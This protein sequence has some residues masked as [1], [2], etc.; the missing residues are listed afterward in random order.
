MAVRSTSGERAV[1]LI[2]LRLSRVPGTAHE[3]VYNGPLSIASIAAGP[4][5]SNGQATMSLSRLRGLNLNVAAGDRIL[6]R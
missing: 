4:F 3:V 2:V 5:G 1:A 6:E